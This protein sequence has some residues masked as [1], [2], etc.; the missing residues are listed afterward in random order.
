MML[1]EMLAD[2][3][4]SESES[5]VF[6]L[7]NY[8]IGT[9]KQIVDE[10][11][12]AR[13]CHPDAGELILLPKCGAF[14]GQ[15]QSWAPLAEKAGLTVREVTL[16]SR[17]EV[18]LADMQRDGHLEELLWVAGGQAS[19]GRLPEA[20]SR[21]DVFGLSHWPNLTR[22]PVSFDE[23]RL[24]ALMARHPTSLAVAS[25]HL[26]IPAAL[27]NR[28][29]SAAWCAGIARPVNRRAVPPLEQQTAKRGGLLTALLDKL[30]R[31]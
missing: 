27:V 30:R 18:S 29:I 5:G 9:L 31:A 19:N 12:A 6:H 23:I 25:G 3:R 20:L 14:I 16:G 1:T 13:V 2:E 22:L 21:L 28:F 4:M 10:G 8:L 26:R 17:E 15:L 24:T 7:D 11:R